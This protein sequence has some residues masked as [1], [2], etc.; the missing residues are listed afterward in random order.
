MVPNCRRF[1]SVLASVGETVTVV[2][3]AEPLLG[4]TE[5]PSPLYVSPQAASAVTVKAASPVALPGRRISCTEIRICGSGSFSQ[6]AARSITAA[7]SR[8]AVW[9]I[10]CRCGV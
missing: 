5:N 3:P 6:A 9:L 4:E 1:F 7:S 8:M 10:I 2:S